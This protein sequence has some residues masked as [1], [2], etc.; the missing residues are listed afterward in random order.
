MS[1]HTFATAA[2]VGVLTVLLAGGAAGAHPVQSVQPPVVAAQDEGAVVD[3]EKEPGGK[4][5]GKGKGKAKGK[6]KGKGK[7]G[8]GAE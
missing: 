3:E 6:G 7:G 2:A 5:E 8:K 4:G 1:T